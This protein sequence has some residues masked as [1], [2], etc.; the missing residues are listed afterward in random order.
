MHISVS[1]D[2]PKRG[3]TSRKTLESRARAFLSL[4]RPVQD[5]AFQEQICVV[6]KQYISSHGVDSPPQAGKFWGFCA[7]EYSQKQ[8]F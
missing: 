6:G 2:I 7:S 1:A 3:F 4:R 8:W 5:R